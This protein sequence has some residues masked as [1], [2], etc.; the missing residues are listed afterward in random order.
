MI[1][2]IDELVEHVLGSPHK[3][4]SIQLILPSKRAGTLFKKNLAA[5]L[6]GKATFLPQVRSIEELTVDMS[7]LAAASQTHLQFEMFKAYLQTHKENP[8]SFI[9]FLA[10]APGVL[11]DF[12]E[13]DR[14][15]L[16]IASFFNYLGAI[17]DMEH[18]AANPEATPMVK[19]YLKFWGQISL[20]YEAF[21][22][23][24]EEQGL[25]Y[26]GMQYRKAAG[27]AQE[28]AFKS[29]DHFIFAGF[30]A[31]N[32]AEQHIIQCFLDKNKAEIFWDI[33]NYFLS[34]KSYSTG[35][36]IKEYLQEWQHYKRNAIDKGS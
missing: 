28:Y 16:P 22:K 10:W 15:L 14:Y 27:N 23:L 17:K 2:F 26:Q 32:S 34:D 12:N 8:D 30:N 1:T 24:L 9:E 35:R 5:R 4:A 21:N 25:G 29:K 6:K 19:N 33:D 7:G 11:G 31:L 36:F 20:F 18:W 3:L 13:I